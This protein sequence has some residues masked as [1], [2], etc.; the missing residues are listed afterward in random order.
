MPKIGVPA[1]A[2]QGGFTL[3]ELMVA[4][5][6]VAILATIAAGT[7][8]AQVQ[9]ARRTDAR[10]AIMDLAG[11]EEKLFST[12][13]AYSSVPA[14]LGYVGAAFP[15]NVGSNYYQINV[16]VPDPAQA[17]LTPTTYIITATP[18][19]PQASDTQC[20]SLSVNQ[21]GVQTFTTAGGGTQQNCWGN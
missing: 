10:S 13:N 18:I 4:V 19:G 15:L 11:R 14:N 9:K 2:A 20:T 17:A 16:V 7:Y 5:A 6:V 1:P 12:T 21:L 8:S 3:V